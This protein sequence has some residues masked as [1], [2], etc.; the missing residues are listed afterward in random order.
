MHNAYGNYKNYKRTLLSLFFALADTNPIVMATF[1][2]IHI[3]TK[4]ALI[5][6]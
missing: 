1:N 6:C 2:R 4:Y 3:C 5:V